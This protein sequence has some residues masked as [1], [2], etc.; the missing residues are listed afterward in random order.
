MNYKIFYDLYINLKSNYNYTTMFAPV[1]P[2]SFWSS[3][4]PTG[5]AQA[6]RW[7]KKGKRKGRPALKRP[8][9]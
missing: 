8:K 9:R 1:A 5:V 2:Q 3:R 7:A 4:N 6:A